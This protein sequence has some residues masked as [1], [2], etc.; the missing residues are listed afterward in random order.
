MQTATRYTAE[1]YLALDAASEQRHEFWE[2]DV[3]AMAGAEPEHN[4]LKSNI[5]GE[6]RARLLERGCRVMTSDQRV[7][8]GERYVYPDVV[9]AC[10][11]EY[12][13][14][15]P[16]TL[17]NPELIVEVTSVS[18]AEADRTEKLVAYTAMESLQ[19]YWIA[20]PDRALL[21][22]YIRQEAGWM[23]QAYASLDATLRSPHFDV[24][25]PL[26]TLYA[27]VLPA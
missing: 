19:E 25:I 18:T 5:A 16:R 12:A 8:L 20:E 23:L 3:R 13:E 4:V 9:V 14:T 21:T 1:D 17:L 27:L 7:E 2:G 10:A 11:P 24:E 22:Q 6:L 26:K 15:R